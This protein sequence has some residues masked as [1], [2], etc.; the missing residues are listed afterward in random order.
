MLGGLGDRGR[1]LKA[2]DPEARAR[3]A[4]VRR[5]VH[6]SQGELSTEPEAAVSVSLPGYATKVRLSRSEFESLVRPA[7]RDSIAMVDPGSAW[8]RGGPRGR[9]RRSCWSEAVAGCR[10]SPRCSAGIRRAD[11]AGTPSGVRRGRRCGAGRAGHPGSARPA[12]SSRRRSTAR[13]R[14][15]R[16]LRLSRSR[17]R[18]PLRRPLADI[19]P[20]STS[21]DTPA[22]QSVAASP[23][24]SEE[25]PVISTLTAPPSPQPDEDDEPTA[26]IPT[27]TP[28]PPLA[29]PVAPAT[30]SPPARP[31]TMVYAATAVATAAAPSP[32]SDAPTQLLGGDGDR[33]E[34]EPYLTGQPT[35][36]YAAQS[37]AQQPPGQCPPGSA[38]SGR[39][40]PRP[41]A[42]SPHGRPS[43]TARAAPGGPGGYPPGPGG[44]AVRFWTV[45]LPATADL[46]HRRDRGAGRLRR[47]AWGLAA[48]VR[49]Q[50]RRGARPPGVRAAAPVDPPSAP[51]TASPSAPRAP[52]PDSPSGRPTAPAAVRGHPLRSGPDPAAPRQHL[53]RAWSSSRCG[54]RA[55]EDRALFL[56][57]TEGRP[58]RST[59][60]I[61]RGATSG[62]MMQASRDTII[63]LNDGVL[64]VMAADGSEDRKLFNRDPAGLRR[65]AERVL[66]PARART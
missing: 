60:A 55:S 29:A 3:L 25:P 14:K 32:G 8:R 4:E 54:G 48:P 36:G 53:R 7:L 56:V 49:L 42:A 59:C 61:P 22:T 11:R 23:V 28:P 10:S 18:P 64:R 15:A 43:R 44:P 31:P 40:R 26:P 9:W 66:E 63:Y 2:D 35:P 21:D 62:P 5:A 34:S 41:P 30:S 27:V 37:P 46:D 12:S 24:T 19:V 58:T 16:N 33:W 50:P 13:H 38:P 45:R 47:S 52:A 17:C 20:V 6:P 65:G 57:D 51:P 39:S 1:D